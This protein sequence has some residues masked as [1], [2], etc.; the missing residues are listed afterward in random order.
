MSSR[1]EVSDVQQALSCRD[2]LRDFVLAHAGASVARWFLNRLC[3]CAK[4]RHD[5]LRRDLQC[6]LGVTQWGV[7]IGEPEPRSRYGVKR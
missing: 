4:S 7:D 1:R 3:D 5:G 2:P 6:Q